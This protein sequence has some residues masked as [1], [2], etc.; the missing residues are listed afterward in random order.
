MKFSGDAREY[1]SFWSQFSKVHEDPDIVPEDKFQYLAQCIIPNS[2]ATRIPQLKEHFGQ[3]SLLVQIFVRD[4]LSLVM[5]NA[6]PGRL[7]T[8]L[9]ALYDSLESKLKAL[10]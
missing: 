4:L 7:D 6:V 3:D 10:V 5:K 2:R 8:N 9:A 1:L